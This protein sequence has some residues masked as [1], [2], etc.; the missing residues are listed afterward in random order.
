MTHLQQTHHVN[1]FY[2]ARQ[3]RRRSQRQAGELHRVEKRV[4]GNA[5]LYR[6][7]C[8]EVLPTL[9]GIG[10]VVTDPPYGIGFAYRSYD[11]APDKYDDMMRRL[12]PEL[13]RVTDNGP[14]FVWQS[15]LR[16][17][18]WHK[19]FPAKFR[20]IAACKIYPERTG[21]S[22]CLSWD[23][24]IFWSGRSRIHDELPRDWHL[25]DLTPYDGYAGGNP[26]PCPRPL[27]QVRYVCDSIQ[28]DTILDPFMGSGTTG[29][30]A[31]L[32]G[33]RFVGIERDPVYFEYACE[34]IARAVEV[35]EVVRASDSP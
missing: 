30:A 14:C 12:V 8:F 16:A 32:A 33:K 29:V 5:T 4:I 6:A 21:K 15:P 31:L 10:A 27:V 3:L 11:D 17:A 24:I 13:I 28:A 26:V 2:A 25:A 19:Y 1:P 23:P 7:D 34:R 22:A 9:S 18:D 20:I 35:S